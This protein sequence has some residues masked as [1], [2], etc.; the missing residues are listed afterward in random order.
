M[1]FGE[2][3]IQPMARQKG[4]TERGNTYVLTQWTPNT[5]QLTLQNGD[6]VMS[7]TLENLQSE[8]DMIERRTAL[9]NELI[10]WMPSTKQLTET[11]NEASN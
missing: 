1:G 2:E 6:Y 9:E 5:I 7:E 11:T 8:N 10:E 4:V 3:M